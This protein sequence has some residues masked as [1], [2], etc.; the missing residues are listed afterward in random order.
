MTKHLRNN[1]ANEPSQYTSQA[2]ANGEAGMEVAQAQDHEAFVEI[3]QQL[4]GQICTYLARLVGNDE[5]GRDLAQE[6][7][8]HAWKGLPTK[9]AEIPLKPWL[10]RIATN[11]AY[12]HLRHMRLIRW[13]SWKQLNQTRPTSIVGPEESICNR[14]LIEKTLEL[15]PKQQRTCLLL[16]IYAELTEHE[17]AQILKIRESSV[18]ANIVRARKRF[19]NIFTRMGGD[20]V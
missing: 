12:S 6:A 8:L 13:Q 10:Y 17:I 7:F 15:L 11:I 18:S 16:K 1:S 14:E 20:I 4:N 19:Y 2:R 9:K 3:F 5:I